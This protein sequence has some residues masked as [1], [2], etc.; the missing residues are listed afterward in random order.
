MFVMCLDCC[1]LDKSKK[2]VD[3][4]TGCY[5]Y[6]CCAKGFTEWWINNDSD[7]LKLSCAEAYKEIIDEMTVNK[8]TES[9]Q[10]QIENIKNC[11]DGA[12]QLSLFCRDYE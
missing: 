9:K 5:M 3:P 1:N 12:E 11:S 2:K 6:G 10:K 7:L 4:S 8:K